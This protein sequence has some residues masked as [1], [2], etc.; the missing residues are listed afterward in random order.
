MDAKEALKN[1]LDYLDVEKNRSPATRRN[2]ERCLVR[3]IRQENIK[4]VSDI[5]EPSIRSFRVYLANPEVNLK[6]RTQAYHVIVIRNFLKYLAREGI[7]TV[8]PERVELPQI[9]ERQI[10][11]VEYDDVERLL[12]APQGGSLKSLRDRAILETLFSTGMRVSELCS[13]DR[14]INLSR[15]EITIRGKGEKLRVVFLSDRA[16]AAIKNYLDKRQDADE[17]LFISIS[18]GKDPKILGRINPRTV[19]RLVNKYARAAGI[20]GKVT[21]HQLRHQFAT[22]LLL[23]GADLRSVQELLGHSNISTTQIY[24]HVT[25]RELKEVHK[26]FHG[27]R[28]R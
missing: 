28:L 24:T 3:F 22:D 25:N 27:R 9:P 14:F 6:K 10:K 5:S 2:Y 21:P 23:N 11:I 26:S 17:P 18:H 4:S 16:R 20:T 13:L 19:Q 1:F 7:K 15:G 12:N 8:T